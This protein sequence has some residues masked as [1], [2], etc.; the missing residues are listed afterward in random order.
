MILPPLLRGIGIGFVIAAP[1]GPIGLLC[2]K[3]T[4]RDGWAFGL[5]TGLGAATADA[6]YGVVVAFGIGVISRFVLSNTMPLHIAG[7]LLLI[8]LGVSGLR[9]A[10]RK[11]APERKAAEVNAQGLLA[12]YGATFLLTLSNVATIFSFMAVLAALSGPDGGAGG[13][14]TLVAGVFLGSTAW[15]LLLVGLITA[16]HRALPPKLVHAI[17]VGAGVLL[18]V[19]GLLVILSGL[20]LTGMS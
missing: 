19:F 15:W 5:A 11:A 20:N 8:W 14:L 3:R 18:C 7:G 12:A 2:I 6:I 1:V 17:E 13:G 4:L 10:L 16:L 9:T